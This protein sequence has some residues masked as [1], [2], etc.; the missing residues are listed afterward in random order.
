[1]SSDQI[2]REITIHAPIERV[3]EVLTEPAAVAMWFGT[4]APVQVDLR[5]G[6]VMTLDHGEHGAYSTVIVNV[7]P[8][9][10][11]SYRWASA[12]PGELATE[13]NSTLVEFT[14][15]PLA[16]ATLLRVVE[17]GFDALVIPPEREDDAGYESHAQGWTGVLAKAR[18]YAEGADVSPLLAPA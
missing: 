15:E 18:D 11:F 16:D 1:M 9:R 17:T 3:W 7:D 13:D 14:L 10:S 2:E 6:G 5:P 8:P 4:G 12:Y